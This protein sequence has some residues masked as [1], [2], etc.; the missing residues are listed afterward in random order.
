M[1]RWGIIS[2]GSIANRFVQ[3]AQSLPD[4]TV[5]AVGSRTQESADVFGERHGIER[6]YASYEALAADPISTRFTSP[7]RIPFTARIA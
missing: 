5:L 1:F 2:T 4:T 6:R 3:G 7:R